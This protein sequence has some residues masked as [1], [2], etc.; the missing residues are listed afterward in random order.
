MDTIFNYF[1]YLSLSLLI[2][3]IPIFNYFQYW[4]LSRKKSH[5]VT[6]Y[7]YNIPNQDF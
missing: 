4:N 2:Q 3:W 7:Y 6:N 5:N 1:Q